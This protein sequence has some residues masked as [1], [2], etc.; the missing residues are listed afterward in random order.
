MSSIKFTNVYE[1]EYAIQKLIS[2]DNNC[3][4]HFEYIEMMGP[5]S[6]L[7]FYKS[8]GKNYTVESQLLD[9]KLNLIT[10]NPTHKAHFLLHTINGS[11]K[12]DCLIKMYEHIY[13]LK[14]TLNKKESPYLLYTIEW[15]CPKSQKIVNSSFY[16]ESI[17]QV[18]LKFNYGKKIQLV[19]HNMKLNPTTPC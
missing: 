6:L 10:Y 12:I 11:D 7:D 17:E 4:S 8:Q 3:S 1:G 19:I 13:Q 9:V 2:N 14:S 5:S 16:G 18:L 15:Y